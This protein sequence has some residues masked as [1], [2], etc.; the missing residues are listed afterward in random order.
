MEFSLFLSSV[1]EEAT[2]MSD[3]AIEQLDVKN[4]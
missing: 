4:I 2:V 1:K 3:E